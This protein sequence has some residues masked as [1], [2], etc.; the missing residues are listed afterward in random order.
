LPRPRLRRRRRSAAP[1]LTAPTPATT[2]AAET[3]TAATPATTLTLRTLTAG[4]FGLWRSRLP[5]RTVA[6]RL[7]RTRLARARWL[8][9]LRLLLLLLLGRFLTL[10]PGAATATPAPAATASRPFARLRWLLLF[11][12]LLLL[13]R[14]A[15]VA[16]LILA[17]LLR[18]LPARSALLLIASATTGLLRLTG[19]RAAVG[20]GRAAL[21]FAVPSRLLL[22]LLDL[23]P[24]VLAQL[25]ILL[26][27]QLVVA[28]VGAA[29]PSVGI[30]TF[31]GTAEDALRER[32][33]EPVAHCTLL[34]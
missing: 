2:T 16:R 9:L 33:G 8:L 29:L 32:H 12:L 4:A 1:T 15:L 6:R 23:A 30:G 14:D 17:T 24:H 20:A 22:E 19:L 28:A 26:D 31:T 7:R 13:R 5:R 25:C 21:A 27:A 18:R 34:P 10:R 3:T 11:P